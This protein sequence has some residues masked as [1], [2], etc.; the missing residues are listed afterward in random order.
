M[1]QH[2]GG[3]RESDQPGVSG[4]LSPFAGGRPIEPVDHLGTVHFDG[5]IHQNAVTGVG[6]Q[7]RGSRR[8]V[9]GSSAR[10]LSR[11]PGTR[12][13]TAQAGVPGSVSN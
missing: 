12:Q 1:G 11:R 7:V 6:R 13:W 5:G 10:A 4:E 9:W 3:G 8:Q 2:E